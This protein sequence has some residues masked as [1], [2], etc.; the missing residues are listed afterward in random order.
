MLVCATFIPGAMVAMLKFRVS[1]TSFTA[2]SR[3]AP[4]AACCTRSSSFFPRSILAASVLA[5]AGFGAEAG[6]GSLNQST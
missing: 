2:A 5:G 6:S 3:S 4:P 1:L